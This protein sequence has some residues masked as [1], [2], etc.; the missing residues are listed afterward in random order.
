MGAITRAFGSGEAAVRALQAG[1]DLLLCPL[2]YCAAFDA[3]EDAV[4]SGAVS[5]SRLEESLRRR[6][7]IFAA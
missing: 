3:V 6:I 4:R 1:A 7:A 2:D 5:E